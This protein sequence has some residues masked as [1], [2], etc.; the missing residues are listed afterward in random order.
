MIGAPSGPAAAG[1]PPDE[2]AL[3]AVDL[4]LHM[5]L[6]G[7][8]A[9]G[10]LRHCASRHAAN[11]TVLRRLVAE[12]L[13]QLPGLQCLALEGGGPL[14]EIWAGA[15]RKRGVRVLQATAEEWRRDLLLSREQRNGR[16]AKEHA[17]ELAEAVRRQ[18]GVKRTSPLRDD[19]AEAVLLGLWA[20]QRLGLAVG[21]PDLRR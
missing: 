3:L 8:N 5:G 14:A 6:A 17:L 12:T 7:Y 19:A 20:C 16:L 2:V 9:G 15:A 18:H 13:R 1:P 4:G 11:R 10:R 21:L